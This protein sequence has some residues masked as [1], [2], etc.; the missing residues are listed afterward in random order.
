MHI[1]KSTRNLPEIW[2]KS[3][4]LTDTSARVGGLVETP[5]AAPPSASGPCGPCEPCEPSATG[6]CGHGTTT[7]GAERWAWAHG[8]GT[9]HRGVNRIWAKEKWGTSQRCGSWLLITCYQCGSCCR[10]HRKNGD[11]LSDNNWYVVKR[12]LVMGIWGYWMGVI[13]MFIQHNSGLHQQTW[14][15]INSWC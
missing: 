6:A 11:N 10:I 2:L 9:V 7:A 13:R 5:R 3:G 8:T 1:N 15:C 14:W 12:P 4:E